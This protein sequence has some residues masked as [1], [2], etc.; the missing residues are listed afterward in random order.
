MLQ[1]NK[2][3]IQKHQISPNKQKGS[4]KIIKFHQT[5]KRGH[6]KPQIMYIKQNGSFKSNKLLKLNKRNHKKKAKKT[7]RNWKSRTYN[8]VAI[9]N[10]RR[11]VFKKL[12]KSIEISSLSTSMKGVGLGRSCPLILLVI[13][14]HL[15]ENPNKQKSLPSLKRWW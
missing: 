14:Q 2:R 11:V 7:Q 10:K 15:L 12:Q 6:P 4:S 13:P 8:R 5:N 1:I 3:V 9:I